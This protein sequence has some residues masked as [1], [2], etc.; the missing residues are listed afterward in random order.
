MS[1]RV[2]SFPLPVLWNGDDISGDMPEFEIECLQQPS[3]TSLVLVVRSS[4]LTCLNST[5][6]SLVSDG[7]AAWC[8]QLHCTRTYFRREVILNPSQPEIGVPMDRVEGQLTCNLFIVAREPVRDYRPNGLHADYGDA[9]FQVAPGDVL[10]IG[11]QF[12]IQVEPQFD[13]MSAPVSSLMRFQPLES[14]DGELFVDFD[15]DLITV[16]VPARDWELVNGLKA[17]VPNLLHTCLAMPVLQEAIEKRADFEGRK[18]AG[19]LGSIIVARR[20]NE[21]KSFEAAQQILGQPVFRG[22]SEINELLLRS[23]A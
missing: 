4:P 13:A 22:L 7:K 21:H 2:V 15:S 6:E 14:K 16:N 18:W 8:L 19:R 3:N 9:K 10:A 12:E 20:I 1:E 5:I 11:P 17:D 23:D